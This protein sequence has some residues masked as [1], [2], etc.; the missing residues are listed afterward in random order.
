M[1][2]KRTPSFPSTEPGEKVQGSEA[3]YSVFAHEKILP[4]SLKAWLKSCEEAGREKKK[5]KEIVNERQNESSRIEPSSGKRFHQVE[6][7]SLFT[8]EDGSFFVVLHQLVHTAEA[9]L[10]NEVHSV[11]QLHLEVFILPH[12]LQR[13]GEITGL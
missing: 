8:G 4:S 2:L 3:R 5:A 10:A 7:V 6:F 9:P 13:H 1:L 12:C 11:L